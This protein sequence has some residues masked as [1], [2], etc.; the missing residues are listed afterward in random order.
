[1]RNG[2]VKILIYYTLPI[3]KIETMSLERRDSDLF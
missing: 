3:S 2:I 1:M